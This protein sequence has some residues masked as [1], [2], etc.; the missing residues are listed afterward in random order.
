MYGPWYSGHY[1]ALVAGLRTRTTGR[2]L[3]EATYTFAHAID[4]LLNASLHSDVGAVD[5][6]GGGP[7]DSFVGIPPIVTDP[8][9][10]QTNADGPFVAGN[11]HPVPQ[12]G[13]YYYGPDLD[14]GASTSRAPRTR[15][16]RTGSFTCPGTSKSQRSSAPRAGFTTA[17][18]R[19]T[20]CRR[21]STA[22]AFP[23]RL[24]S[25]QVET[26]SSR[27]RS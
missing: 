12:G 14:R 19:S 9:T 22:T 11:G 25:P 6:I 18:R 20:M 15:C 8:E 26:I 17:G 27:R 1:Q 2:F 21:T 10:G 13:K 3:F 23:P 16:R 5:T 24:I 7:T 4:N